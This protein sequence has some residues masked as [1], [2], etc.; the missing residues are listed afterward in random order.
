VYIIADGVSSCNKEET[1]IA[2][3][4]LARAGATVTSSES[5]LYECVGDAATEEFKDIIQLVK[6]TSAATR[7][8]LQTLCK[9]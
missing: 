6:D 7:E 1:P 9:M 3:A 4:R 2:L 5:F 8:T